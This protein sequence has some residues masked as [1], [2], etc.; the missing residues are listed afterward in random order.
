MHTEEEEDQRGQGD[1]CMIIKNG[2]W[3]EKNREFL[4]FTRGFQNFKKMK[5]KTRTNHL[6]TA[7][8]Y[9]FLNEIYSKRNNRIIKRMI[10][11]T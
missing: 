7:K 2:R 10:T 4:F 5:K 8:S 6:T 1:V 9:T 3:R 11:I